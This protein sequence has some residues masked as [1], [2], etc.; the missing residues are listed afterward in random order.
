M[1]CI[2]F[3]IQQ[4]ERMRY[5]VVQILKGVRKNIIDVYLD[6]QP[7]N[8]WHCLV[9]CIH[10][11]PNLWHHLV[12]QTRKYF[13]SSECSTYL[14]WYKI[15]QEIVAQNDPWKER[16]RH[17]MTYFLTYHLFLFPVHFPS[18]RDC[19]VIHPSLALSLIDATDLCL[20]KSSG[21]RRMYP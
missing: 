7:S 10:N 12:Q 2:P 9:K 17:F 19:L 14:L 5:F 8:L 16:I 20:S 13:S 1:P 3:L 15:E 18:F 6:V 11:I 4:R 21:Y